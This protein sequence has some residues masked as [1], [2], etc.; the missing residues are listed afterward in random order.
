M[1][2]AGRLSP[3]S[4]AV[5]V[6]VVFAGGLFALPSPLLAQ[7]ASA[8]T[9]PAAA[10][11]PALTSDQIEA[12][13]LNASIV[14]SRKIGK[15]VTGSRVAT[16]TDGRVTHDAHIQ[17]VNIE[18]HA[19]RNFK[20]QYRYNIAAYRI[21]RMLGL[22]N[23][24]VS[25]E[26][27]IDDIPAAVTWWVDGVLMDEEERA[28]REKARKAPGWPRVRTIGYLQVMRVFDELI[29]NADRNAGNQLWTNDGTLWLIDH[30][31]AFRLQRA[32]KKPQNL[33]RCDRAVW[34]AL[35]ELTIESVSAVV[36]RTLTK[37]EIRAVIARRNLI[38][39]QFAGM[40]ADRGEAT[41]LFDSTPS[42]P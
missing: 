16:M 28:A 8:V 4:S 1:K 10:A 33:E 34:K 40:I 31:R 24:P 38:V 14:N 3:L 37:D 36:E 18:R 17:H 29:A 22:A 30:T 7:D 27:R 15:G 32:L 19:D 9:A 23:V 41:I 21:A 20:D 13:L 39:K 42:T 6:F 12:F 26:R 11:T 5:V 35:Q 25:V 2:H